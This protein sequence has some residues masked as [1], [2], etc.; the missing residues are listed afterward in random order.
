VV[1]ICGCG[2]GTTCHRALIGRLVTAAAPEIPVIELAVAKST[3]EAES[4]DPAQSTGM[5]DLALPIEPDIS[6]S[7]AESPDP[8]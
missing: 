6:T 4:S 2:N 8:A 7:P 3:D 5:A 1:V